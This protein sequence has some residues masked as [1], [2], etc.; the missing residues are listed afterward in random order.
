M[1][2]YFVQNGVTFTGSHVDI[3][4]RESNLIKQEIDVS[5]IAA[6]SF[7]TQQWPQQHSP[8]RVRVSKLDNALFPLSPDFF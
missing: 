4:S 8:Q 1:M 5:V 7:L 6:N 2:R 3:I